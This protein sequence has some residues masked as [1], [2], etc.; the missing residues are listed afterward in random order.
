MCVH[1]VGYTDDLVISFCEFVS[2]YF[3]YNSIDG[4]FCHNVNGLDPPSKQVDPSPMETVLQA[5]RKHVD[6]VADGNIG[7]QAE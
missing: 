2:D 4:P 6:R 7:A 3:I 1:K 5:L